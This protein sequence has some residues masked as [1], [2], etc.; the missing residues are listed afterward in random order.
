MYIRVCV[1][2]N[3]CTPGTNDWDVKVVKIT[4]LIIAIKKNRMLVESKNFTFI[5]LL[6]NV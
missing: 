3:V 5:W 1:I 2:A 4:P 6:R